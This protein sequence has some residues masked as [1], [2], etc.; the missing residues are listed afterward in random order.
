MKYLNKEPIVFGPGVG[1]YG[2]TCDVVFGRCPYC[3]HSFDAQHHCIERD[4]ELSKQ[5]ELVHE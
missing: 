1:Q 4:I 2:K 5:N 3:G